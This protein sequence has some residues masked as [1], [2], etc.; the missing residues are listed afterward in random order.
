MRE[1]RKVGS[2]VRCE[3][4]TSMFGESWRQTTGSDIIIV[5]IQGTNKNYT[6][7]LMSPR[8]ECEKGQ[9]HRTK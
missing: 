1:S 3:V 7:K 8:N 2:M 5:H 4:R 6:Q 9:R